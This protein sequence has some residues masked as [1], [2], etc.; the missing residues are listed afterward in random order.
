MYEL[1]TLEAQLDEALLTDRLIALYRGFGLLATVLASVGLYGVM[2]FVVARRKKSS[3]TA[4]A[5]GAAWTRH[6]AGDEG[7]PPAAGNRARRGHSRQRC[8]SALRLHTA[9]RHRGARSA[10]R[11]C[12]DDSLTLVSAAAGLIP[13]IGEPHR[14]DIGAEAR[15]GQSSVYSRE[16]LVTVDSRVGSQQSTVTSEVA[17]S[18][19]S[20][21]QRTSG[22]DGCRLMSSHRHASAM[23]SRF[24]LLMAIAANVS[25]TSPASSK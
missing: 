12:N 10:D 24:Q 4:G 25:A 16:S 5:R 8:C 9:L 20:R 7:V 18:D 22:A 19:G 2:A 13:A 1:K 15:I 23:A 3:D 14:S 11:R 6:L 17:E 21:R